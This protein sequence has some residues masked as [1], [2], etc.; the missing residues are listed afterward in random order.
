M[1]NCPVCD[2][3]NNTPFCPVCGFDPSADAE[4]VPTFAPLT[5]AV[6]SA[7]G[8]RRARS[9]LT[10]CPDCGSTAFCLEKDSGLARCRICGHALPIRTAKK[11]ITA[12]AAGDAHTAVLYSDGTVRCV[13]KNNWGQCNTGAWRDIVAI[14][15]GFENTLGLRADG[16]VVATGNN[17]KGK[18]MVHTLSGIRGIHAIDASKNNHSLFLRQDGTVVSLG[19]NDNG[20]R[21]LENWKDLTAVSAGNVYSLGLKRDGTVLAAGRNDDGRCNT[22]SWR[23]ITAIYAGDWTALGL[24]RDGTAVATGANQHHQ[25][26]VSSWKDLIQLCGGKYFS[27]GLRRDG[28]VCITSTHVSYSMAEGWTDIVTLAAGDEH[29]VGLRADGTLVSAGVNDDGQRS[30]DSLML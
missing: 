3:K 8:L 2:R 21:N 30:V 10:L 29:L 26:D 17:F 22:Q 6:P 27:A 23:D 1:W 28:T 24:K 20:Q 13:G 25:C 9:G 4:A 12:I 7:A 5:G 18:S 16:T 14:S 19:N 11:A 15:A